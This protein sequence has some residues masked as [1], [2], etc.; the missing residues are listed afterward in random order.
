MKKILLSDLT[1]GILLTLIV[2]GAFTFQAD[3][4][5]SL[6]Q[7][8][9][10]MRAVLRQ[11]SS[12]I[13]EIAIVTIDDDSISKIG[14]WPWPRSVIADGIDAIKQAGAKAIGL[15]ILFSEQERNPGL[16]EIRNLKKLASK[17]S[18]MLKALDESEKRLDSDTRLM[19]SIRDAEKVVLPMFFT[20]GPSLGE[21]EPV[22]LDHTLMNI[23]EPDAFMD[24]IAR[25]PVTEGTT[26]VIPL[27]EFAQFSPAI[28]HANLVT[29]PDGVI[30]SEIPLIQFTGDLYPSFAVQIVREYLNLPI[31]DIAFRVGKTLKIG[32][33]VIPLDT[34]NKMLIS[35][36]GP[37]SAFRYYSFY[38]VINNKI[39]Q[40]ALKNKVVL[41]G[42]FATGIAD[43]HTTPLGSNFPGI[44]I[45]ANIIENILHDNHIIRPEWAP[46]FE[47]I[48]LLVI[49]LFV[50]FLLP[51][52]KALLGSIVSI[53]LLLAIIASGTYFFVESGYWIKIFYS[54]F[55]LGI[56][57]IIITSKR[58][59]LT[60]KRKELVEA[61]AIETNRMLGLSFQGQ[62]M[63]DMAFDKFRKCPIDDQMKELLYNLGLDFERKRQFNKA[64]AVY[65]HVMAVDPKYKGIDERIKQLKAAS[66]GAVF[67]GIGAKKGGAEGTVIIEG[68]AAT[69][70]TLGRYTI[71][72]E[73]GRGAM[74]TVYLGKDPKINRQV[75]IKTLRFDDEVDEATAK[76]IKERF[77]REAESAG[78]LNHPNII[79]IFDAG[80]D[81]ELSY[82]AM[83]LLD[84]DDL[85]KFTD[86]ANL[87]P[88]PTLLDYMIKIADG[89]DYAHQTGVY[90]RDI[91]P[92][93]IMLLK[94]GSLR[95]TDFGIARIASS[96]KTATGT[97]L[98]TPSY[99]SPEQLSGKKVD[100]RSDLFSY[101]VMLYEFLTGVKPFEGESIAQLLYKIGNEKHPNPKEINPNIADCFI[102]VIDKCLEKDPDNRYQRGAE[103]VAAL[104][105]CQKTIGA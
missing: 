55:L 65:E 40:N 97:V 20:I 44:V 104:K 14:R 38:D 42:H 88:L 1:I 53:V 63:L 73:L 17:G 32:R 43:L 67:G 22:L 68:S 19:T 37:V 13:E 9:Y 7:K 54:I 94:D 98:G 69:A 46:K 62:G 36:A 27:E 99:M 10:D 78:N 6:E 91:K 93:N 81:N 74:G 28:G 85:K 59:L 72:K 58:F 101:G 39:D 75:A 64:A 47:F 5:E 31:D 35:Y 29:D 16:A 51:K 45:T 50:S 52:L 66:E 95:I 21:E 49:G 84:G 86:K 25:F 30:R 79:K 82:I 18:A 102:A 70:P 89:L 105:E 2:L 57:Y 23:E 76:S 87:L 34:S 83:E 24:D 26:P 11:S 96:S 60:E 48:L 12:Q 15:N 41:V 3:L 4:F 33:A 61:S 90:H 100:G 103:I 71:V 92:A 77:F 56:G 80:E 8:T